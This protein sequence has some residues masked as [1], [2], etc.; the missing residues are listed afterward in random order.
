[1]A[2]LVSVLNSLK[3]I[4]DVGFEG[5]FLE[6]KLSQNPGGACSEKLS[7]SYSELSFLAFFASGRPKYLGFLHHCSIFSQ[8][9]GRPSDFLVTRLPAI[10]RDSIA[11]IFE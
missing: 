8:L 10:T 2:D 4:F 9:F 1:L 6:G 3:T 11:V 5:I 7:L